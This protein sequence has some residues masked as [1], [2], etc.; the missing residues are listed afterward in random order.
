MVGWGVREESAKG[1]RERRVLSGSSLSAPDFFVFAAAEGEGVIAE[2]GGVGIDKD[3]VDV[4]VGFVVVPIDVEV[5]VKFIAITFEGAREASED[6]GAFAAGGMLKEGPRSRGDFGVDGGWAGLLPED[7]YGENAGLLIG[8]GGEDFDGRFEGAFGAD[9]QDAVRDALP[10]C[11]VVGGVV[12]GGEV[13]AGGPGVFASG[14][15]LPCLVFLWG[16]GVFVTGFAGVGG[17][18]VEANDV[19]FQLEVDGGLL[20]HRGGGMGTGG[21]RVRCGGL[22]CPARAGVLTA[23]RG[24]LF[25]TR[26]W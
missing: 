22:P 20:G 1:S 9:T 19:F 16:G 14:E 17:Q 7:G 10:P 15:E 3:G 12:F 2:R 26:L 8:K 18:E 13:S 24:V 11:F 6:E 5:G 23:M 4:G 21:A 25:A